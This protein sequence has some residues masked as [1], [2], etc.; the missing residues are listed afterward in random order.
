MFS[1]ID[2]RICNFYDMGETT[3]LIDVKNGILV[4]QKL[5]TSALELSKISF[6]T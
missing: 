1:I 6:Y 5:G 3:K 4:L 2:I